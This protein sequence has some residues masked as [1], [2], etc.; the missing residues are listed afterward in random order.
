MTYEIIKIVHIIGASVLFG[1]GLGIAFFMF[2]AYRSKNVEALAITGSHVVF[3]DFIFTTV[4]V[5]VQ[6]ISGGVLVTLQGYSWSDLWVWLSLGLYV[7]IGLCWLPVVWL[8]MRMR[9]MA[10]QSAQ[11]GQS[12]DPRYH[13]YFR[14]WFILGWPAFL[15][16]IGIFALMVIR[17]V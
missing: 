4:A 11:S 7:F 5:I 15:A 16:V 12:L 2:M 13:R 1:T 17:P 10:R 6:P 8:Q 14:M 9:D 3:A